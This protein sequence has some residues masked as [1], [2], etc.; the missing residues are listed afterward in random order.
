MDDDSHGSTDY[1]V[2]KDAW[3]ALQKRKE[4]IILKK[5]CEKEIAQKKNYW[6]LSKKCKKYQSKNMLAQMN[7]RR[8]ERSR[9]PT[10]R[11]KAIQKA[12][13]VMG[14]GPRV[15]GLI[16]SSITSA[17]TSPPV[18]SA[19]TSV[20]TL[21][22][23]I[24][25]PTGISGWGDLG[26][27][28]RDLG[29]NPT[30][31]NAGWFILALLGALPMVGGWG[32][33]GKLRY[34]TKADEAVNILAKTG[35]EGTLA[36]RQAQKVIHK[37]LETGARVEK[38]VS[39]ARASKSAVKA[40]NETTTQIAMRALDSAFK[41]GV[42]NIHDFVSWYKKVKPGASRSE[43][44][45]AW[46]EIQDITRSGA[47]EYGSAVRMNSGQFDALF[48]K[49]NII[50]D[51]DVTGAGGYIISMAD[52]TVKSG[53]IWDDAVEAAIKTGKK[54]GAVATEIALATR[55]MTGPASKMVNAAFHE[56]GHVVLLKNPK[57]ARTF[58]D[59][60]GMVLVTRIDKLSKRVPMKYQE[61]AN[62]LISHRTLGVDK[63]AA[64]AGVNATKHV[65]EY[66]KLIQTVKNFSLKEKRHLRR[67][68]DLDM[69]RR[70]ESLMSQAASTGDVRRIMKSVYKSDNYEMF[71]TV[72]KGIRND[73]G[74][75]RRVGGI[76]FANFEEAF[77][78]LF[79]KS[80]KSALGARAGG[81]GL[82]SKN[83]PETV[84]AI[85]PIIKKHVISTI[86]EILLKHYRYL[87]LQEANGAK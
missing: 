39:G 48:K 7:A 41:S 76:Y 25:D 85:E 74:I 8:T 75:R 13:R 9:R 66:E 17:S 70:T 53:K 31:A 62:K 82:R 33:A 87:L 54:P 86:K 22:A 10:Q 5:A 1:A 19:M 50:E 51:P 4:K 3:Y 16:I 42:V 58:L 63:Y 47:K 71:R 60:Y 32:R 23:S 69:F 18:V 37:N 64:E 2:D 12:R 83:F 43:T 72:A 24:L 28:G 65:R 30:A 11:Q 79:E 35:K 78:E 44:L 14:G 46:R 52:S 20:A 29:Q 81:K 21:F 40:A 45:K 61:L 56:I 57:I 55:H 73:V 67:A 80:V 15:P 77:A 84:R 59:E 38:A 36:A 27:A 6:S 68:L 49:W 34:L 26:A